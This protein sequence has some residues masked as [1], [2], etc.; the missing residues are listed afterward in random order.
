MLHAHL[1]WVRQH[2]T[3]PMGEEWLFQAW[4][5]SYLPLLLA[6]ERLA[7]DGGRDL[8]T[9]GVSPTLGTQ[10][11]DPYLTAEFHGWLGRRL[12]DLEYTVSRYGASDREQLRDVWSWHWRRLTRL[13]GIVEARFRIP[14][15]FTAALGRL[16]D[17]GVIEL[18]GGPATHP[19]LALMDQPALVRRQIEDGLAAH[20]RLFG[21]RPRGV[22]TPECAYRP[23]GPVLD[24]TRGDGARSDRALPGLED[25]WADAGVGHLVLDGPTLARAAGA[26]DRDWARAGGEVV[27]PGTPQDVLDA[28]ALLGDSEVAA[29]GRNL[30]VSYAVW[31]PHG[32]YPGDPAYRDFGGAD[33]EGGFKSWRV[34]SRDSPHKD[35]Y[36]PVRAEARARSHAQEFVAL[37][38][39]HLDPRPTGAVATAAYD[40]ELFGHWWAEGPVWLE[41]VL[42]TIGRER[43]PA[44]ALRTT[45]LAKHLEMRPAS[46][47]L[48]PPESTWGQRKDHSAWV[49]RRTVE[50]W[51]SVRY[52]EDAFLRAPSDRTSAPEGVVWRQLALAQA[53]DW[54]FLV[55]ADRAAGYAQDRISAHLVGCSQARRSDA[56][57]TR[58]V[59]AARDE[60][61][62]S[63]PI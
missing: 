39:R 62:A 40:A 25:F 19:Q 13:L 2:G 27:G 16:G 28:P 9:L 56:L 36:D 38:H 52:E 54:P 17:E 35:P 31:S 15:A 41:Q 47:R 53:S 4:S 37:L 12:V 14:G 26:A 8:L 22:W 6:L 58:R 3:F 50:L 7:E 20:E 59:L 21:V 18:L 44:R 29:F 33:M 45:T 43:G 23:A 1:P 61:W 5:E 32:G 46:R 42:R 30:A 57:E 60:P 63:S 49:G 34:T 48:R 55:L 11:A 24:P 51:R 10:L